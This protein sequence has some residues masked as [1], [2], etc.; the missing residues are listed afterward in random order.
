M[1]CPLC[2]AGGYANVTAGLTTTSQSGRTY[3][4]YT[5]KICEA[6]FNVSFVRPHSDEFYKR[7]LA[8]NR[9][10]YAIK[11]Y[12]ICML[13][14]ETP[15][16]L[17]EAKDYIDNL[18]RE[19]VEAKLGPHKLLSMKEVRDIEVA[20]YSRNKLKA[21]RLYREF[22]GIDERGAVAF[23]EGFE[24]QLIRDSAL[25]KKPELEPLGE[26]VVE[27][28][29]KFLRNGD[30]IAALKL[31]RAFTG[32]DLKHAIAYVS[33]FPEWAISYESEEEK[34]TLR[35]L[36]PKEIALIRDAIHKGRT[37]GAITIYS[38]FTGAGFKQAQTYIDVMKNQKE[39]K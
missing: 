32:S 26:R 18:E 37:L 9:K 23:I 21:I 22:S 10:I 24:T 7:M 34:P 20:L 5:C 38:Q 33:S 25:G 11:S 35:E 2:G 28:I 27:K 12:R 3:K 17:R 14:R 8:A 30:K 4:R 36:V 39:G 1:T 29:K 6:K 15:V 16:G 19:M 13:E 31:Y